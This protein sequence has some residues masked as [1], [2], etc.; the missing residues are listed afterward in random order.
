MGKSVA[1]G[2]GSTVAMIAF[3]CATTSEREYRAYAA[4]TT[5]RLAESDSLLMRR[6]GCDSIH[7]PYNEMLEQAA[8]RDDLEA[9]VLLHQ[10]LSIVDDGFMAKIRAILAMAPDVAVIGNAGARNPPG[11]AW[12]EGESYGEIESPVLVPGG[13]RVVYSQ[14]VHEVDCVDGMLLVLSAWAARELRFDDRLAGPLDGYDMDICF[15]ARARGRRV[16]AGGLGVRHFSTYQD[17]FDRRRWVRAA[18]ALERKWAPELRRQP[19]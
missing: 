15:Q 2:E 18:V 19:L 11:L 16:V 14:G 9:I 17:F 4:R 13:S 6:H 1:R 10:D 3:G 5:E 8:G 7:A 12:W